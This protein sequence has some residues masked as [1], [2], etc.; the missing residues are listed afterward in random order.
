MGHLG[1]AL[2]GAVVEEDEEPELKHV[3]VRNDVL[4][5]RHDAL[6]DGEGSVHHLHP[7]RHGGC[8]GRAQEGGS[9]DG[10]RQVR[11]TYC[12]KTARISRHADK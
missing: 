11:Q 10:S 6:E 9:S 12:L 2:G 1:G 4:E 3:V 8:Q 7:A 5:E